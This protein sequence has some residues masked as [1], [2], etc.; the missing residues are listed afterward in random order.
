LSSYI[1]EEKIAEIKGSVN[2]REIISDHVSLKK[3]GKNYRGLCPFHAEKLPSFTVSEEKQIFHC[4]G[5]GVGG[6]VFHFLMKINNISFPEAIKEVAKICGTPLPENEFTAKD[7]KVHNLREKLFDINE[8]VANYYHMFLKKNK[9]GEGWNYFRERGISPEI[10]DEF[11]LGYAGADGN[12]LFNYLKKEGV[13]LHLGEMIGLIAPKKGGGGY[14]DLLRKRVIFPIIDQNNRVIGFGGRVVGDTFPKYLNSPDSPIYNKSQ[15]M[16]GLN[17][18]KNYIHKKNQALIV[19]GYFDL[20]ALS[21]YGI[22]NVV[23]TLGT[24]LTQGASNAPGHIKILVRY[25]KNIVTIFDGDKAGINAM[26]RSL[27]VFFEEGIS[28]KVLILPQGMDPDNYVRK[29]KEEK[30]QEKLKQ[31]VPMMDFFIEDTIK[32][33]HPSSVE[34]KLKIIEEI[35]PILKK[36]NDDIERDHYVKN[37]AERLAI[38]EERIIALIKKSRIK[39]D[40][41]KGHAKFESSFGS[42]NNEAERLIIQLM[43]FFNQTVP[44]IKDSLIIE[45]FRDEDLKKLGNSLLEI[46][47]YQGK[48]DPSMATDRI[49]DDNL[50][51]LLSRHI[52]SEKSCIIDATKTLEDCIHKI[53]LNRIRREIKI[54]NSEMN[55]VQAKGENQDIPVQDLLAKR[56]N[57]LVEEKGLRHSETSIN[58]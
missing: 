10:I 5:C 21:Q 27:P 26:K 11:K 18:A 39:K 29:V 7:K 15:S 17:I 19:E 4:F 33:H 40:R 50:R 37:V 55:T 14:Y 23:A 46:Y 57:L 54:I 51:S 6:N 45:S 2:I 12:G 34:G 35:I 49:E 25:S 28:P 43:L 31:V 13:P 8:L 9:E 52:F 22:K 24:A 42:R 41:D 56:Q 1:P 58:K 16:Y 47:H 32:S 44:I 3:A 20:L 30:F 36:M 38:K 48:I 53:K